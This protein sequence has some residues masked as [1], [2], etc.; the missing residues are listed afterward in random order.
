MN[1]ISAESDS[2]SAGDEFKIIENM[3]VNGVT[4]QV[5]VLLKDEIDNEIVFLD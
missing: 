3:I 5:I 4:V 1:D 2:E